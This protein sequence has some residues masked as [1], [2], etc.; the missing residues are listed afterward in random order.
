MKKAAAVVATFAVVLSC[1]SS[2]VTAQEVGNSA[3]ELAKSLVAKCRRVSGICTPDD[4]GQVWSKTW[5]EPNIAARLSS[6]SQGKMASTP[7]KDLP[8]KCDASRFAR[9]GNPFWL[10]IVVGK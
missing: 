2:V 1:W 4:Y 9:K 8:R 7:F 5:T 6:L 3:E 10:H